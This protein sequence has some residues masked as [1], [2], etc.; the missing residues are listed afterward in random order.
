M[1]SGGEGVL[2]LTVK[3]KVSPEPDALNHSIRAIIEKE[4]LSLNK[5]HRIATEKPWQWQNRGWKI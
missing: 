1:S 2:T 4:A 5:A 3:M